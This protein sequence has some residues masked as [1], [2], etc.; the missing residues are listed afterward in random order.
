MA[1]NVVDIGINV[2]ARGMEN[3]TEQTNRLAS[4]LRNAGE[5]AQGARQKFANLAGAFSAIVSARMV[6]GVIKSVLDPTISWERSMIRLKNLVGGTTEQLKDLA[7]AAKEAARKT[8]F[9]PQQAIDALIALRQATGDSTAAKKLL[10]P[11]LIISQGMGKTMSPQRVSKEIIGPLVKGFEG[12]IDQA[13]DALNSLRR[14]TKEAGS[15]MDVFAKGAMNKLAQAGARTGES[16]EN[17]AIGY[18]LAMRVIDKE[19]RGSTEFLRFMSESGL[20]TGKKLQYLANLGLQTVDPVTG[21][22]VTIKQWFNAVAARFGENKEMLRA[23]LLNTFGQASGMAIWGVLQG[24]R[25]LKKQ[26]GLATVGDSWEFMQKHFRAG[27]DTLGMEAAEWGAGTEA[28]MERFSESIVELKRVVGHAFAPAIKLMAQVLEPI[29]SALAK[30]GE[31]KVGEL[32]LALTSRF[33]ALHA[34]LFAGKAALWGYSSILRVT[35]ANTMGVGDA[36]RGMI[37]LAPKATAAVAQAAAAAVGTTTIVDVLPAGAAAGAVIA[38][39]KAAGRSTGI[40]SAGEKAAA[41]GP[42]AIALDPGKTGA[43]GPAAI[44]AAKAAENVSSKIA[45]T[46]NVAAKAGAVAASAWNPLSLMLTLIAVSLPEIIQDFKG[47]YDM[48]KVIWSKGLNWRKW[49]TKDAL[50]IAEAQYNRYGL[51]APEAIRNLRMAMETAEAK[52][53]VTFEKEASDYVR[54]NIQQGTQAW[55]NVMEKAKELATFKP[56]TISYSAIGAAR[57]QFLSAAARARTPEERTWALTGAARMTQLMGNIQT[58]AAL[59]AAGKY[60][61][62]ELLL[63]MREAVG[64]GGVEMARLGATGALPKSYAKTYQKKIGEGMAATVERKNM[65]V[66]TGALDAEGAVAPGGRPW[67]PNAPRTLREGAAM[68]AGVRQYMQLWMQ[69]QG[70]LLPPIRDL[71]DALKDKARSEGGGAPGLDSIFGG[72]LEG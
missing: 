47:M 42:L 29:G 41:V 23:S 55:D 60:A 71:I 1:M 53:R 34:V 24:M 61:P 17:L 15:G 33:L 50:D 67:A 31:T 2:F 70:D 44:R 7:N 69:I 30:L 19:T 6:V 56:A 10:D 46:G 35:A 20:V 26:K 32:I 12:N 63:G 27:G 65:E 62:P 14:I 66:V 25:T 36:L 21:K 13:Y 52:K 39:Q 28:A 40:M 59:K 54:M 37:G 8:S 16:F 9:D 3:T 22:P 48:A 72:V 11:A 18:T 45:E 4:S 51:E 49:S 58:W 43:A 64:I 57:G 68:G 5:S 38:S